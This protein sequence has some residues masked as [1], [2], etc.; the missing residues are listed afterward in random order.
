[1]IETHEMNAFGI[2]I[3]KW[4]STKMR[5]KWNATSI[6]KRDFMVIP[7]VGRE[8]SS[9]LTGE[10]ESEMSAGRLEVES[11]EDEVETIEESGTG[12]LAFVSL[13]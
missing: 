8:D 6:V 5:A 13:R 11:D 12:F 1:M 9:S 7:L 2:E 3:L 10:A 4:T